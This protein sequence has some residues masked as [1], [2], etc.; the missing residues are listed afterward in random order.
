MIFQSFAPSL[1]FCIPQRTSMNLSF[2][3][4]AS[5][6]QATVRSSQWIKHPRT[7]LIGAVTVATMGLATPAYAADLQDFEFKAAKTGTAP[8]DADNSNGNDQNDSN[9][10]VRTY[11]TI[12]YQW[13][14]T[15][16]N[17]DA[18]NTVLTAT[19]SSDQVWESVP[20]ACI[21]AGSSIVTN[22]DNTQTLTCAI[23]TVPN[24]STGF[25]Q[26][27]A[28]IVGQR[29]DNTYVGDGDI[30]TANASITSDSVTFDVGLHTDSDTSEVSATPKSDL[31]K[32]AAFVVGQK[33]G[34][35]GT[36]PGIVVK[37]P[38]NV[39]IG[40]GK[41]SEPLNGDINVIDTVLYDDD[42]NPATPSIPLTDVELYDWAHPGC[43]WMGQYPDS[44]YGSRPYGRYIPNT[45]NA[46]S[47]PTQSVINSGDW[48]CTQASPGDPI[49]FNVTG[50]NTSGT[51]T[52]TLSY[53]DR[54]IPANQKYL[55]SGVI[56]IWLPVQSVLDK[57]GEIRLTNQ[58]GALTTPG[59]S[60]QPNVEP[61]L[62]NNEYTFTLLAGTGSFNQYY[63][64]P[65]T[66]NQVLAPMAALNAGDG[67]V[68]P[69][70]E[71]S[72]RLY[73]VNRGVLAWESYRYCEKFD[74]Q[75]L[76]LRPLSGDPTT[77]VAE[78]NNINYDYVI[79]YGTGD[80]NGNAG[81][82]SSY[83]AMRLATCDDAESADGWF[84]D[85]TQVPGGLDAI[86]K[87][88]YIATEDVP[89][90][91]EMDLRVDF[92]ARNFYPGTTT[93]IP[94]GT[95]LPNIS[96]YSTP[97][98][99]ASQDTSNVARNGWYVGNYNPTTHGG[100]KNYGDRLRLTRAI[101]RVDKETVPNDSVNSSLAGETVD[102]SLN[103]SITATIDPA[104]LSPTVTLRDVLPPEMSYVS[105][106]A[107]IPPTSVTPQPNGTTIIEWNLG[108]R[109][110]NQPVDPITFTALVGVDVLNNTDAVNTAIV[111]SPDDGSDESERTDIRTVTIGNSAAFGIS[112]AV[113]EEIIDP[114]EE[115]SYILTYANTGVVDVPSATFIDVLPY[116]GD[117]RTPAT[118]FSG[119]LTYNSISGTNGETFEFTNDLPGNIS[120]DPNNENASTV[121]CTEINF[122]SGGGC[123]ANK[124]DVTGVKIFA[125]LYPQG[126]P[127]RD[128]TLTL[129]TQ[130]NAQEDKYT[131]V[132]SGRAVGFLGLL[133]APAVPTQV[134]IPPDVVLV[135]RIT[136]VNGD[137]SQ[138][139]NDGT[140]FNQVIDDTTPPYADDDSNPNWPTGYL[141]GALDGGKV[142]TGDEIEYTVYF[143][144]LGGSDAE[145]VRLCDVIQDNQSLILG[146]YGTN[147]DIQFQ[148][149]GS[150]IM[151]LTAAADGGDRGEFIGPGLPVPTN[152]NSS[153]PN[154]N[155][156]V[157]VDV[158]GTT[159]LPVLPFLPG[160]EAVNNPRPAYGWFRFK[161]KVE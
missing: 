68:M 85:I 110:P 21:S 17:G 153:R 32:N 159:G 78:F 23:G 112:K 122:G 89:S 5:R 43:G 118:N 137:R 83:D 146:A 103:P 76:A 65:G 16:N 41:G 99:T 94:V 121:W 49:S 132:F 113:V 155:G 37:Y 124:A 11:D 96:A 157:K 52:P 152:C 91:A 18:T 119:S 58:M 80:E 158:T 104:P 147:R 108:T 161:T 28:T 92:T 129:N 50:A 116:I 145:Q 57:G 81:T 97:T 128:I 3:K 46:D 63:V 131:N 95:L 35:D 36:T 67:V 51:T 100:L 8:F 102:F 88:R 29:P 70:Q 149:Q 31:R 84:T 139:P 44:F 61:S 2:F 24:A 7:V 62:S 15:A 117:G 9:E 73:G 160:S 54:A 34:R 48:T 42:N 47:N 111:E 150:S 135:K 40:G 130:G 101:V 105:G 154:N 30:V 38:V 143:H 74:N 109:V 77:A 10:F 114:D 39:I 66:L 142:S 1:H 138:N 13:D 64:R 141:V 148:L 19:L 71:F 59:V 120:P 156:V 151:D 60:G 125:P 144:N 72:K 86:T 140:P 107:S 14:Y 115:I 53:N 69:T 20:A 123:P 126:T 6:L 75:V 79:E 106:S 33:V 134:R 133:E 98:I 127:S 27:T 26:A 136:A 45:G 87:I 82:Y 4:P 22:L 25:I 93:K 55:I 12:T 56:H 90:N